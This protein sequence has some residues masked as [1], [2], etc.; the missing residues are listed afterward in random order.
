MT[1]E[2]SGTAVRNASWRISCSLTYSV[3]NVK[4]D[5]PRSTPTEPAG[6]NEIAPS[7]NA[8]LQPLHTTFGAAASRIL[9]GHNML[10]AHLTTFDPASRQS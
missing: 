8:K 6:K 7:I 4:R 3:S 5:L 2:A 10:V 1:I 9:P